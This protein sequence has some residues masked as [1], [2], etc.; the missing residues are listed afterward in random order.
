VLAELGAEI[1][2]DRV[3]IQPGQP[4][5]FGRAGGTFFF[6]L[7]GNPSSTMVTFEIF[8]RAAVELLAGQNETPLHM[9]FSRLTR[10]FRH[11]PGLTRFLP[12]HL[13][14]DGAEVTPVE[15]HGSGD[16]PALTRANAYL[17]ADPFRAEYPRG[18][19]IRVLF[20]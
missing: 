14:S 15:W 3:L 9:P 4:L 2:F 20:K 19:L 18:E 12:A 16:V 7:P 11:R 1:F 17:V 8:A 5:V 6:G 13:S 10:D